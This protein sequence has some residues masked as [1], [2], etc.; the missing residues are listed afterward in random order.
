MVFFVGLEF[1]FYQRRARKQIGVFVSAEIFEL[2]IML[3]GAVGNK[4]V[5]PI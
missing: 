5:C 4:W 1:L 3:H 2:Q